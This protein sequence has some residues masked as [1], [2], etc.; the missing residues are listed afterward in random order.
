MFNIHQKNCIEDAVYI[1]S[2]GPDSQ[3]RLYVKTIA[4]AWLE[5]VV[6]EEI[7]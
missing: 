1:A 5:C 3:R 7:V 4:A 2:D 6:T